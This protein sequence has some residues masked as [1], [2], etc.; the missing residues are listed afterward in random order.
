MRLY[1]G[2]TLIS[3]IPLI[4]DSIGIVH[5]IDKIPSTV[6]FRDRILVSTGR[7]SSSAVS[8]MSHTGMLLKAATSDCAHSVD[9]I[10]A[11]AM[12]QGG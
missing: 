12:A 6:I 3:G 4:E 9:R 8:N 1:R 7:H 10:Q 11:S 2:M 5:D